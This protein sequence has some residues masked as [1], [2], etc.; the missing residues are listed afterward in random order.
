M[1]FLILFAV[2]GFIL[3]KHP[4]LGAFIV[5]LLILRFIPWLLVI[6]VVG[7][8]IYFANLANKQAA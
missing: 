7:T 8:I 4:Y 6:G 5:G 3:W 1:K 2:I